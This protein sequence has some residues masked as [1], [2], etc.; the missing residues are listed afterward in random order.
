MALSTPN[1]RRETSRLR[2]RGEGGRHMERLRARRP[3]RGELV[4]VTGTK[5][6]GEHAVREGCPPFP[7]V[8]MDASQRQLNN[9]VDETRGLLD[10]RGNGL[11]HWKHWQRGDDRWRPPETAG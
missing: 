1:A 3:T 11:H 10:K 6:P 8:V 7:N 2:E 9:I 5:M 4:V